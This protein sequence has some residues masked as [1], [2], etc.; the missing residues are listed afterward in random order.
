MSW[1]FDCVLF[2][3]M[4]RHKQMI[5][6]KTLNLKHKKVVVGNRNEKMS[7]WYGGHLSLVSRFGAWWQ[8]FEK[9]GWREQSK[10]HEEIHNAF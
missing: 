7:I 10:E 9:S 8:G 3:A 5:K 6:T 4:K 2:A 1:F